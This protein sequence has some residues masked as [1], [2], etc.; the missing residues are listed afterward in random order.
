MKQ[1]VDSLNS[2]VARLQREQWVL[3]GLLLLGLGA[4]MMLM[5]AFVRS[6]TG[7]VHE[8]VAVAQAVAGGDLAVDIPVR[9]SN[10]LG[11]LMQALQDMKIHLSDVVTQVRQGSDSVATASAEIASGNQDLSA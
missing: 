10:E 8:A 9:G 4:S 7:P 1:V 3:L 5:I 11:Q 2:R 6:I